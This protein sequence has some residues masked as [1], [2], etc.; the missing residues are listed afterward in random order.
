MNEINC[1]FRNNCRG[2]ISDNFPRFNQFK[3]VISSGAFCRQRF[4]QFARRNWILGRIRYGIISRS[5]QRDHLHNQPVD[6][7]YSCC[8]QHNLCPGHSWI[9]GEIMRGI[10]CRP[11]ASEGAG[12]ALALQFLADQLT[13]SQ[14]G[15]GGTLSPLST[16]CTTPRTF[17][18]CDAPSIS[19]TYFWILILIYLNYMQLTKRGKNHKLVFTNL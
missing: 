13:L 14:P 11:V 3:H 10:A 18:P 12:G 4:C 8:Q 19:W 17:R 2:V 1:F 16:T 6:F 7:N 5:F 15:G 9:P